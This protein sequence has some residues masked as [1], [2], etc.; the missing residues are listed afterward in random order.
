M[1]KRTGKYDG[2]FLV[3]TPQFHK[4]DNTADAHRRMAGKNDAR[5]PKI[6]RKLSVKRII[7]FYTIFVY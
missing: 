6:T 2:V 1:N 4:M 3:E 7:D 5:R